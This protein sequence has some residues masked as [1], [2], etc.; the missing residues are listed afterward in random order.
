MEEK[1]ANI[2]RGLLKVRVREHEFICVISSKYFE[3]IRERKKSYKD[4]HTSIDA[5]MPDIHIVE[6]IVRN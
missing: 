3:R 2:R 4:F 5:V 6:Y 1:N